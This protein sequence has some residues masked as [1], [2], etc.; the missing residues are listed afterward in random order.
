MHRTF[1]FMSLGVLVAVLL[2]KT[3]ASFINPILSPLK[4]SV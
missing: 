3:L 2:E 1:M 4:L